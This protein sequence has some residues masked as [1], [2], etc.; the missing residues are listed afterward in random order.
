MAR[1]ESFEILG[2]V[3][4][5]AEPFHERLLII[6]LR[7]ACG[8]PGAVQGC[9]RASSTRALHVKSSPASPPCVR[10]VLRSFTRSRATPVRSTAT[11]ARVFSTASR[12]FFRSAPGTS[13]LKFIFS[14]LQLTAIIAEPCTSLR[15]SA[16]AGIDVGEVR[17]R[18]TR[19]GRGAG[20]RMPAGGA[21]V[22]DLPRVRLIGVEVD[23]AQV[24]ELRFGG[25]EMAPRQ[26]RPFRRRAAERGA[27]H[28]EPEA[29]LGGLFWNT[30]N[31]P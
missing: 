17:G 26:I 16:V 28:I 19:S 22:D 29:G 6:E 1:R 5:F 18:R 10:R 7:V 30:K 24:R 12:A 15:A 9:L 2:A 13:R 8:L 3:L 27:G 20:V 4:A 11:C 21:G 31:Q 23:V 14:V 25:G